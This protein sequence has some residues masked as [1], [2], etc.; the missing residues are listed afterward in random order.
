MPAGESEFNN[1]FWTTFQILGKLSTFYSTLLNGLSHGISVT[2]SEYETINKQLYESGTLA[3]FLKD[4]S[5]VEETYKTTQ[6]RMGQVYQ[7][8]KD[9]TKKALDGTAL[10][11]AHG[12][13]DASVYGYLE[14]LSLASPDSFKI[15]IGKKQVCL[16][17][18]EFKT[19]EQLNK[20]KIEEYMEDVVE[21]SSLMFKLD[22]L[23][24]ITQPTNTQM[25]QK[26]KYDRERINQFN[27]ARHNI[28]HGND[29]GRYSID[30]TQESFYWHLLNFY[31]AR[32]VSQKTGL[33]LSSEELDK[34]P[35]R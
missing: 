14:V 13:L 17:D 35:L 16:T 25:N 29:W 6:E 24:E 27:A 22:K 3:T 12:I 28:V 5:K 9:D 20:E 18:I 30:F 2:I 33:K 21:N 10:V 8:L 23:H 19:Y 31:L 7:K 26:V 1:T 32:L 11:Y 34:V 15:Y 4:P